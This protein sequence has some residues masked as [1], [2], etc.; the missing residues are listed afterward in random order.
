MLKTSTDPNVTQVIHETRK[1]PDFPFLLC[2]V[3]FFYFIICLSGGGSCR[4]P[5][6]EEQI[7]S[8]SSLIKNWLHVMLLF[9][10]FLSQSI[11]RSNVTEHSVAVC[12]DVCNCLIALRFLWVSLSIPF[13]IRTHGSRCSWWNLLGRCCAQHPC[14]QDW[15]DNGPLCICSQF[16]M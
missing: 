14:C 3:F 5:I 11:V 16:C 10:A 4:L 8:N 6:Q 7:D 2:T 15:V 12:V 9:P 1:V 13:G